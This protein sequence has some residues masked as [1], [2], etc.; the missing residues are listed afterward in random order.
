MVI[1]SSLPRLFEGN[2]C[3]KTADKLLI[4]VVSGY[5][6]QNSSCDVCSGETE[7]LYSV[8][9]T[10]DL[11]DIH[12]KVSEVS[13][14]LDALTKY[15]EKLYFWFLLGPIITLEWLRRKRKLCWVTTESGNKEVV[16]ESRGDCIQFGTSADNEGE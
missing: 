8:F 15:L 4:P 11:T 3:A 13:N 12:V 6:C 14:D 1:F 7:I 16:E 2:C 10:A 5:H 9:S